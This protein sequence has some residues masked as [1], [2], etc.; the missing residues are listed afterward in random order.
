M[1]TLMLG[2]KR[3]MWCEVWEMVV[4]VRGSLW[5]GRKHQEK[6]AVAWGKGGYG[7]EGERR[8]RDAYVFCLV[9]NNHNLLG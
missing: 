6:A 1:L 2:S 4:V 5:R 3:Y 7:I 8:E 9:R